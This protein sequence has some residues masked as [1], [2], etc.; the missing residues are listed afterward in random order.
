MES[1]VVT[2]DLI[3]LSAED[4]VKFYV[5]VCEAMH[6]DVRIRP[7]QYFEQID[8]NGKHNLILY[9]LRNASVQLSHHHGLSTSL[10]KPEIQQDVVMFTA[11]V[12]DKAGRTD[13]AVGAQSLK[14]LSGKD[15]ADAIMAAQTKAKRRAILDFVGSGLLDESEVEG[16]N[17][18][19]V[20]MKSDL[21]DSYVPPPPAPVPSSA[22]AIEVLE[23]LPDAVYDPTPP[24]WPIGETLEVTVEG[25]SIPSWPIGETLE[26][27]VKG[28]SIGPKITEAANSLVANKIAS[29]K[30][31]VE[32][33][34]KTMDQII[35][36]L[37]TYRRDV[38]Q[39][40]GMRPAKG[41]GIAAKWEKFRARKISAKTVE[42]YA[43]LLAELDAVL[44]KS[45]DVGVV[46]FIEKEIA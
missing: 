26:V 35:A 42:E 8:R 27:T 30:A 7:L 17:G 43:K 5:Q 28:P 1:I 46:A 31:E 4:R 13:S 36:R 34:E 38:L 12:T 39:R 20:E 33:T 23:K 29:L 11:I 9:A 14:G 10:S 2:G 44:A 21:I 25:P 40:G 18:S 15:Y 16:M 22:P 24:S 41:L 6:L 45:G 37:N 19:P 3:L 32:A